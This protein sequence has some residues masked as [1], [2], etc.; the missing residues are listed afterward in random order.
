MVALWRILYFWI[1]VKLQ[2]DGKG[3]RQGRGVLFC[4]KGCACKT[5]HPSTIQ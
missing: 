4:K 3:P 5:L 2:E 1:D